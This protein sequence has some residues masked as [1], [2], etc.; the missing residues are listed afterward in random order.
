MGKP[1]PA[2]PRLLGQFAALAVAGLPVGAGLA[3]ALPHGSVEAQLAAEA[4]IACTVPFLV[5]SFRFLNNY[6]RLE[7][8]WRLQSGSADTDSLRP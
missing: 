7:A 3:N 4:G 5:Y 2:S 6:H 1:V 8:W